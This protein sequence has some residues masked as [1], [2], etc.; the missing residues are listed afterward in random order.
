MQAPVLSTLTVDAAHAVSA[1]LQRPAAPPRACLV[2]AHGAGAGMHHT[3]M[4]ASA[5]GLA[6]RGIATLRYQFPSMERGSRRPDPPALAHAAVRAAVADA[7]RRLPGAALLAGGKSFGGRMTSQAQA[8]QPL[9]GVAGLVFFGFPL[10]PAGQPGDERAAHLAQ[11]GCPMLFLQGTRDALAEPTLMRA[12][13]GRLG[14]RATAEWITD[15]DH[16]FHVRAKSGRT[17]AEVL[18]GMLD[19][20][21]RWIERAV[22]A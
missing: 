11:V 15:A 2:F 4:Q 7:A 20:V 9:A 5:D 10:H 8:R 19:V 22:P 18:N 3:F 13:I 1:L 6:E 17:D 12:A 16:A 21:V 14:P